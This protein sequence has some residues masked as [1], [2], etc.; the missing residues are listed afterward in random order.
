MRSEQKMNAGTRQKAPT[1]IEIESTDAALGAEIRCGDVRVL[2]NDAIAAIRAA[3]L[4]HLV[5]VFRGQT[6]SDA[7]LIA[8]GRR[9][10]EFQYSNPLPS[11]LAHEGKARQGG[12]DERHPEITVVSN[13]VENGVAIGGFG[14]AELVWHTDMSSF[15][16]PPH[17]TVLYALEVPDTGGSTGFANMYA[18]YDAL[19]PDLKGQ[20][21]GLAL[22]HD[23][24]TDAAG[25]IRNQYATTRD[26]DLRT[27]PGAIHPLVCTHPETGCDY[28]YLGRRS[29]AYI[30]NLALED[31]ESLLDTLWAHATQPVFAWRHQWRVG[32]LV[33]WDNRCV[34]HHREP[35][36][37]RARRCLHRVVIKGSKPLQ[38]AASD[39]QQPHR[40][41][42][43]RKSQQV[44]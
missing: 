12:K 42:A 26:M 39:E 33:M 6:L 5:V 24:T 22:K 10:G 23:A 1:A 44:Y 11:P 30:Q 21:R 37:E 7:E 27:S 32:D 35:F 2:G 41:A 40:R 36:D 4:E 8:F 13:I 15:E 43:S 28:L 34:L 9:F 16:A 17:Q 3:W 18:A 38:S 14:D 20:V 25:Y 31:S 29:R 19:P